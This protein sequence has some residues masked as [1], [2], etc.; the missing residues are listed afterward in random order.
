MGG[1]NLQE[2]SQRMAASANEVGV[3]IRSC[4]DETFLFTTGLTNRINRI[5]KFFCAIFTFFFSH[6]RFISPIFG[7][8]RGRLLLRLAFRA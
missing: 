5:G 7:Y 2:E 6:L 8:R 1:V 3:Q 4:K